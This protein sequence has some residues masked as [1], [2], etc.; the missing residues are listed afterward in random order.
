MSSILKAL[1]KLEEE[2]SARRGGNVDIARG[3]LRGIP[4]Y[5]RKARWVLPA[6]IAGAASAAALLTYVL[7]GGSSSPKREAAPVI[8]MQAVSDPGGRGGRIETSEPVFAGQTLNKT[9]ESAS[10][11][12]PRPLL[13]K[14]VT[15]AVR[16]ASPGI[17]PLSRSLEISQKSKMSP[18]E[19]L[20]GRNAPELP[21]KT[22]ESI[23]SS[24]IHPFPV[25][26]VSGIAWH[27]DGTDRLAIINGMSVAEGTTIEGAR[28]EEIFQDKV[29][30]S[31]EK[32]TFD[33]AVGKETQ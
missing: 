4:R 7:M 10:A 8:S 33:V 32:R 26:K 28:V 16:T 3:V 27:K 15:I 22:A 11:T 23:Q 9:D 29:R 19:Q 17:K 6:S 20:P 14:K 25:L 2:K 30:F 5:S 31:F 21:K 12:V 13:K 18:E 24:G 1:K